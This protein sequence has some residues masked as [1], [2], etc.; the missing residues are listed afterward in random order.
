MTQNVQEGAASAQGAQAPALGQETSGPRPEFLAARQGLDIEA[1]VRALKAMGAA[2]GGAKQG[3]RAC[4]LLLSMAARAGDEAMLRA[5]LAGGAFGA[6]PSKTTWGGFLS[7]K[8]EH[9]L[10]LAVR[11]RHAGCVKALLEAGGLP[12]PIDH[13]RGQCWDERDE[14][15][16]EAAQL[17]F[18]EC[19]DLVAA[20]AAQVLPRGSWA[21]G[22]EEQQSNLWEQWSTSPAG[23]SDPAGV[24][25]AMIEAG[26]LSELNVEQGNG[27]G[28]L[29]SS[30]PLGIVARAGDVSADL[31]K[32]MVVA[33][34]SPTP[35]ALRN[36]LGCESLE[37]LGALLQA[38]ALAVYQATYPGDLIW[39][40]VMWNGSKTGQIIQ[41]LEGAGADIHA[42][43]RR[44][45]SQLPAGRQA[46]SCAAWAG[47][48][49]GVAALL[50]LG[51][52]ARLKDKSGASA[53]EVAR[54]QGHFQM[55]Q[56]LEKSAAELEAREIASASAKAP[57]RAPLRM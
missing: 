19:F 8:P 26:A 53:A 40:E 51:A 21:L 54:S 5:A 47:C 37:A 14:L 38:G 35:D 46:L 3:H 2:G 11:G 4:N 41:K 20:H 24:S 50:T 22:S 13:G 52:D 9:P 42:R 56:A 55:A 27:R 31:I 30:T 44:K 1:V 17:G 33:G 29:Q 28:P 6:A 25:R 10:A 15:L 34:A 32:A 23:R 36:A 49:K 43:A 7:G 39:D 18:V 45:N 57:S 16:S 12:C 48:D